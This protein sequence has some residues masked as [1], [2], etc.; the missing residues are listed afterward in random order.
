M[1]DTKDVIP[2][3]LIVDDDE[4]IRNLLHTI[5]GDN[6]AC[7]LAESAEVALTHLE[8]ETFDL[9]ISDINMGAMS[10]IELVSRVV[11]L[12]PDTIVMVISGNTAIDSAIDAIRNGAFDYIKKPFDVAQV[13][14]SVRR[15]LAHGALLVSKRRHEDHLEQL[16]AERTQR[17]N[18]LAYHDTLTG[19][20][21][22]A[23][24]EE[25]LG[26]T[27][28]KDTENGTASVLFVSLDRFKELRDTLGHSLG[29]RLMREVANRLSTIKDKATTVARFEG[30][31][32]A[33]LVNGKSPEDLTSFADEV[34]GLF[35]ANFIIG[36]YEM[37]VTV[38][39]GISQFPDHG[40]DAQTLLKNAGAALAEAR[41]Q[42]GNNYRF[43]TSDI[44]LKAVR[45]LSLENDLRRALEND[46]FELYYQPKLNTGTK[47]LV[48]MEALIRWNHPD[49]GLIPPF[50]FIPMAEETG[51]IVPMGEWIIRTACAQTKLWHDKGYKLYVAVNLSACQF[52]QKDLVEMIDQIVSKTGFDPAYLNLEVTETAIMNNTEAAVSILGELRKTGIQISIDDFGTGHSSLGYLKH[53]PID[54]LKI[55][56]SFVDDMATNPDDAALVSTVITLTHNLRL[57]VVAEGVETE[58]QLKSLD[59]LHCDEWQGYLCSPPVPA[60]AFEKLLA[61]SHA[62]LCYPS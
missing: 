43:Y 49:L 45:R 1:N 19:L 62:M 23:S 51:L 11:A 35:N 40:T 47:Q 17:L 18:Y 58:E 55:D 2:R 28:S 46:E 16:V 14:I 59:L 10:G 33:L 36:E 39:I 38:S 25:T 29:R 13:G 12:S 3:V 50:D 24:F 22:R 57:K 54:V 42:G 15:A 8:S 21:N 27:L 48:G 44:H 60:E 30:N 52:Q 6:Y 56:K 37:F 4:T 7:T 53:L 32:F 61:G 9:V 20:P 26:Q 34:L 5:L 41:N 31:E